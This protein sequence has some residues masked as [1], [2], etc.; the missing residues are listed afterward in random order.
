MSALIGGLALVFFFMMIY[1]RASGMVANLALALNGLFVLACMA[2][3]EGT[4][5]LP[6]LAGLLLSLGMAVDAN[7]LIFEHMRESLRA[8]KGVLMA[9]S[10]GYR[11]CLLRDSRR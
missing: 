5:T 10:E 6:G 4:L 3:F 11:T 8:G 9:I 2:A 1:Y 7:V